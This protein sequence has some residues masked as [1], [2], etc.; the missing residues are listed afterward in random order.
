M[1]IQFI[2]QNLNF[3]FKVNEAYYRVLFERNTANSDWA[4]R[5]LDV[6]RNETVYS[7]TLNAVVT[8]D[9]ELAK[10]MIKVYIL[11]GG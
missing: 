10:E 2:E 6:S 9:T 7:K 5:L 4:A 8:P 3:V 11:R 1:N